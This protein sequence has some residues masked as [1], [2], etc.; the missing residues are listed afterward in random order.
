MFTSSVAKVK[1]CETVIRQRPRATLEDAMLSL[2]ANDKVVFEWDL[3]VSLKRFDNSFVL[4]FDALVCIN[5]GV[6]N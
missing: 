1:R 2:P 3:E 6:G 4:L 5:S